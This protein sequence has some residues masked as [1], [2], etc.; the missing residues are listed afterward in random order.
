MDRKT[1]AM[2]ETNELL[3]NK[4]I[5]TLCREIKIENINTVTEEILYLNSLKKQELEFIQILL[6][7]P[8]GSCWSGFMLIDLIEYSKLPVYI[9]GLG[10][11]AS[12]GILLLCSGTKGHRIITKNTTLLS[13]QVSWRK[14]GK[15][16]ELVAQRKQEEL[17]NSRMIN[18][19]LRHTNLKRKQIEEILLPESDVW[20]TPIEAKKYGL[21]DKIIN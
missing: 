8:G 19:Y 15:Y 10:I 4:G 16:H 17:E 20:L 13:H 3:R 14:E 12:M 5:I 6:N 21:V 2:T 9:T 11:C 7:S 1:I 18:H